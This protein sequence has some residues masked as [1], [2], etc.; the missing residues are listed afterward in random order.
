[1]KNWCNMQVIAFAED[2]GKYRVG[3]VVQLSET[4]EDIGRHAEPATAANKSPYV[5]IRFDGSTKLRLRYLLAAEIDP[6]VPFVTSRKRPGHPQGDK[7]TK[8]KIGPRR[9]FID[10]NSLPPNK[11]AGFRARRALELDDEA[12][13]E[14]AVHDRENNNNLVDP[15]LLPRT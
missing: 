2:R 3:D 9:Y 11:R 1:M 7:L 13:L 14:S 6:L 10:P 12:M 5:V 8:N 15:N 4:D